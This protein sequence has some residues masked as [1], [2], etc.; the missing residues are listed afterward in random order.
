M[1]RR[2]LLACGIASSLLYVAMNV[3]V[4]SLW[5]DYSS[6]S[7]TV[8]ELSAIGAP[9]RQVWIALAVPYGLLVTAFGLGVY[10]SAGANGHLRVTGML[11]SAYGLLGFA[12]PFAPMHLR[13]A[14]PTATDAMHIVFA[15]V[16]V[17]L[18]LVAIGF[19]A[20]AFGRRFRLYSIATLGIFVVFGGLTGLDGP[21][22]AAN[23]PTPWIGVWERINIGAFLLWIVVLAAALWELSPRSA[24]LSAPLRSPRHK[25]A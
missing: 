2:L 23:L 8:S 19:G 7:Q 15:V 18:M 25:A 1:G 6:A 4:A 5:D 22:I 3:I 20:A 21:R 24:R 16:T 17:T 10:Q 11:L 14:E 12:W 13:G 9:T